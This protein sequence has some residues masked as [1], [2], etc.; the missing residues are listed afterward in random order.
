MAMDREEVFFVTC[1]LS[2]VSMI[3]LCMEVREACV[4]EGTCMEENRSLSRSLER[5]EKEP[6]RLYSCFIY[7]PVSAVS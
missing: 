7:T 2:F 1:V 3:V 4:E 6:G 5:W